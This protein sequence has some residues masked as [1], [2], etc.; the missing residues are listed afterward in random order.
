MK[1]RNATGLAIMAVVAFLFLVPVIQFDTNTSP[2]CARELL[3]CPLLIRT[4]ITGHSVYWS[5]TAY[6][7]GFG[8]YFVTPLGFGFA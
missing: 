2:I 8:T 7:I 6:Y 3:P 5:I 4:P 1:R